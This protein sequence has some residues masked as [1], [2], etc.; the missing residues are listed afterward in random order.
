VSAAGS[1]QAEK[2]ISPK[3]IVIAIHLRILYFLLLKWTV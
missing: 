1:L 2:V 3:R